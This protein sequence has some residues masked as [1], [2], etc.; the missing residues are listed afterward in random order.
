MLPLSRL[1]YSLSLVKSPP[2][3]KKIRAT[4]SSYS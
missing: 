3:K 2:F 4:I 1:I